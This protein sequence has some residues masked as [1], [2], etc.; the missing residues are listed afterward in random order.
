MSGSSDPASVA[1]V[2]G[3]TSGSAAR[4]RGS[5][6]PTASRSWCTA[7][8]RPGARRWWTRSS[9]TAAAP[10]SPRPTWPTRPTWS[11]SRPR[12]PTS[13]S[14]S[15]TRVLLVRPDR[16]AHP[17]DLRRDVRRQRPLGLLPGGGDRAARWPSAAPAD[18]RPGQ[19]GLRDRPR[20]AA[21]YG[22]TK[23][24]LASLTRSWRGVQPPGR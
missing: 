1:L 2:T 16:R 15:T 10:G 11:G 7:W 8:T 9:P 3:A 12:R 4:W 24:A 22:A 19:H 17:G 18:H 6:P 20:R 23:A 5:R 14:S 13:T 21:A